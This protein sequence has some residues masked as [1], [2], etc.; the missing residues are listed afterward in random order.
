METTTKKQDYWEK[1]RQATDNSK[2]LFYRY[3]NE[4]IVVYD[5]SARLHDEPSISYGKTE[6]NSVALKKSKVEFLDVDDY[7]M[8]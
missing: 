1:F 6:R 3:E 5:S 2:S 4:G 7:G 8:K